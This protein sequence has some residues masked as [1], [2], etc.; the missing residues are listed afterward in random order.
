VASSPETRTQIGLVFPNQDIGTERQDIVGFA[1]K[2]EE[3]GLDFIAGYD[4]VVGVDISRKAQDT[5]FTRCNY[6]SEQ[7]MHEPM[8]LFGGMAV[9]TERVRFLTACVVSPQRQTALLAKQSAELDIISGGRLDLGLSIG[10]SKPEFDAMGANFAGRASKLE[11]QV[12]LLRKLWTEDSVDHKSDTEQF[13][14]VDIKPLPIQRPIPIW[15]GGLSVAAMERAARIGDGWVAMSKLD[16]KIEA[17]AA[18]FQQHAKSIGRSDAGVVGLVNPWSRSY[19]QCMRDYEKWIG[20]GAT[21]IAIG[22]VYGSFRNSDQY[23]EDVERFVTYLNDRRP[24]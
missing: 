17:C 1:P 4:H 11:E 22:N 9:L 10:W 8:V 23:F 5:T 3:I 14:A 2:V 7:T 20:Y 6:N 18:Y 24:A 19:D 13:E 21:H 16:D 15:L 12:E